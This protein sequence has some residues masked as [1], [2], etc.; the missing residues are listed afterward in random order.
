MILIS[1]MLLVNVI[2]ESARISAVQAQI[3]SYTYMSQSQHWQDMEDRF[4]KIMEYYLYGKA[5]C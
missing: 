1:V 2:G 5:D 4:M 3:K